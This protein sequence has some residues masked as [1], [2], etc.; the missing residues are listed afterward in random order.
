MENLE[1]FVAVAQAGSFAGAA[2]IQEVDPSKVSRSI[3]SLEL[4]LGVRLFHRTTRKIRLTEAGR[5][6][7][8]AIQPLLDQLSDARE[9]L[10]DIRLKVAG[11]IRVT[12][13]VTFGTEI[14]VPLLGEWNQLHPNT[15]VELLLSDARID[16]Q[17]GGLD[18]ALRMGALSQAPPGCEVLVRT[19]Y[20]VCASPCYLEQRG[21]I[22]KPQEL[23]EREC[24]LFP[25]EGFS[26]SWTFQDAKHEVTQVAVRGWLTISNAQALRAC[27]LRGWGPV[28]LADW[29]TEAQRSQ[30]DLIDLFPEY[31]VTATDFE[32]GVWLLLPP[33][34]QSPNRYRPARVDAFLAFL[35]TKLQG[36]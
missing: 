6:Y 16:L 31:R 13:S 12:A 35:R 4:E 15:D 25:Y 26:S 5:L 7:Y 19:R 10:R 32:T 29:M 14:L 9:R 22:G 11:K 3:A 8:Q 17:D 1:I 34:W 20:R 23:A 33:Q 18:L 27:A 21:E 30:G 24:L 28:L 36:D 2:A